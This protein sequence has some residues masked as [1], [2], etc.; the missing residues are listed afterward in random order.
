MEESR[1][2]RCYEV[3]HR[4]DTPCHESG[5]ECPVRLAVDSGRVSKCVHIHK[6]KEG[7]S[8]TTRLAA[9]PVRESD[10]T[11]RRIVEISEDITEQ[12]RMQGEI[13]KKSDFLDNILKNSPDGIIGNDPEGNIFQF[14]EAAERIFGYT[15]AQAIGKIHAAAL[16][17]PGGAREVK[18]FIYAGRLRRPRQAPGFRDEDRDQ[19]GEVG[20]HPAFL[21]VAP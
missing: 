3:T 9:Y 1:K 17:P 6:D 19:H 2:K 13:R 21:R 4:N 14:N 12:T 7:G 16:Y 10:G 11:T 15:A 8:R 5:E 20:P 18:E